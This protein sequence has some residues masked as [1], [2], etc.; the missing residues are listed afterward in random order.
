MSGELAVTRLGDG[1]RLAWRFDGPVGAPVLL[2]SNSLG[3]THALWSPQMAAFTRTWRVLRYDVRGHG[4]S[5]APA[6]AYGIDRLARDAV[7]L[8]DA[9]GVERAAFCGLSMGGMVGQRLAV[10][11]PERLSALVLANTSAWMGPGGWQARIAAAEAQG[12]AAVAEAVI[13][14]WFTPRFRAAD[15]ASVETVRA[16]LLA[17]SPVG[18]AGCCAALRDMDQRATAPLIRTPTLVVAGAWDAATPPAHARVLA[19]AVPDAA[20]VE[21]EAAHLSNVEAGEAFNRAVC[22]F[23]DPFARLPAD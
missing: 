11:A 3:T 13:A 5:D 15:P 8:L 2:L 7:E 19:D 4:A 12:M 18:Y 14:R 17:T 20:Y 9:A 6:G 22:A 1:C 16:Q 21:L 23:L 10:T